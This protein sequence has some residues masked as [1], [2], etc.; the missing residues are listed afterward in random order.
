MQLARHV[1]F[2]QRAR[3]RRLT[4]EMSTPPAPGGGQQ[5]IHA[6]C[7]DALMEI[8]TRLPSKSVLRCRAVCRTW[9][10][11]TTD[12]SFLAAHRPL[13]MITL[14]L[15]G[16]RA[17]PSPKTRGRR[18][19]ARSS[20]AQQAPLAP[21]R[22]TPSTGCSCC[23]HAPG[24]SSS[25]TPPPGSG[26]TCRRGAPS[27]AASPPSPLLLH[28][29]GRRRP[30][31]PARAGS[32]S[33]GKPDV[34]RPLARRGT[35][36]WLAS[37]SEA[38]TGKM[39]GFDTASEA[40]RLMS[41]PPV[42]ERAGGGAPTATALLDLDGG[43]E[44]SVAA[45]QDATSL[46]VWALQDYETE[47]WTLRCRVVVPLCCRDPASS[48]LHTMMFLSVGGGAI[49]IGNRSHYST[50]ARLYDLKEKRMRGEISFFHQI[51]T[52]QGFRES[53]VSHA[54]FD[55]PRSSE[56]AYKYIKRVFSW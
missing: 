24:C 32:S 9:R 28:P 47:T 12:R 3:G 6:L 49:L 18:K 48:D 23:P 11:L 8:L 35:L 21:G 34:R 26:P 50:T 16:A 40:F 55:V 22:S 41:R 10:R 37:H 33:S 14:S 56:V 51:P 5:G 20:S 39:L 42:P 27:H 13:Q 7:E 25:A 1:Q 46:A 15:Y 52:F 44:L 45:M 43:G 19:A 36:H 2:Y 17:P 4:A 29:V 54:F 53:L 30:G 38:R 31:P